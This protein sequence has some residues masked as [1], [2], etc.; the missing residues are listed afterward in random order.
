MD[1]VR[2]LLLHLLEKGKQVKVRCAA[3]L[4][5]DD[6]CHRRIVVSIKYLALDL[7][8]FSLNDVS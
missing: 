1:A 7:F 8:R 5:K 6:I 2:L 3:V 4:M